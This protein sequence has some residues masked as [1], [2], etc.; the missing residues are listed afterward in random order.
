[1]PPTF[2]GSISS[3][4]TLFLLF[5]E[6]GGHGP[7]YVVGDT[8]LSGGAVEQPFSRSHKQPQG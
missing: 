2:H 4:F 5:A 8:F 6:G 3:I 1:M 7:S